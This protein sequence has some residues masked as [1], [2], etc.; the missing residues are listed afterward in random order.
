MKSNAAAPR[1]LAPVSGGSELEQV[2]QAALKH[3]RLGNLTEAVDGYN[4]VL[5]QNPA[6]R[7]ALNNL[8]VA[9]RG[10]G[11]RDA[12]LVA[13]KRL[14][15]IHSPRASSL[16]N[17]GN[18]LRE[19]GQFEECRSTFQDA[20]EL[21]EDSKG[22][23]YGLGLVSRDCNYL[24][25]SLSFL[26]KALEKDPGDPDLNWDRAQTLLRMGDYERGFEAY[27][28]RWALTRTAVREFETPEWDG[29]PL[30]GRTLLLFG[31]QGFG[32][33]IQFV[34]FIPSLAA[35]QNTRVILEVR[36][37]LARLLDDQIEGVEKIVPRGEGL[38]AHDCRLPL[39]SIPRMLRTTLDTV[40]R[41]PYIKPKP[42]F[43]SIR[44]AAK[45]ALNIGL[46][47]AG[48]PSQANDRNRTFALK[49]LLPLLHVP[50]CSFYSFQ[51]GEG[52]KEL[53]ELGV[54]HMIAPLGPTLKDFADSS[55]VMDKLDLI[56]TADTSVAHL[57]GAM[58][59]PVWIALS[60]FHDWRYDADGS[61]ANWYPS[62]RVFRQE[63]PGDWDSVFSRMT[64]ELKQLI[65]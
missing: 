52:A 16:I 29:T 45:G 12:A 37:E 65:R 36:P 33:A 27:E 15:S 4:R 20:I 7:D 54:K 57:A 19:L 39:L 60:V 49:H 62:A 32:D 26:D 25:E 46:A 43:V 10:L 1:E 51:K 14:H 31:E 24:A 58:G 18:L 61:V 21:E 3:Q 64:S 17:L 41:E 42:G 48:S 35:A 53:D 13:Y 6:A 56:I 5:R 11:Q 8:G 50:N 38:P 2:F 34:R 59:K 44:K 9:L 40:P 23:L 47:W 30:D 63:T 28:S 55:A 22:A